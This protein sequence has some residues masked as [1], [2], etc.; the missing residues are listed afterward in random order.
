MNNGAGILQADAYT[1][2]KALYK[3]RADG[4]AQFR[5][6]ASWAHLRRDFHDIWSGTK[7]VIAKEALD[8]IGQLYDSERDIKG[9]P[10]EERHAIRQQQ[11]KPKVEDFHAW[12]EAQLTC[13]PGK[14]DLAKGPPVGPPSPCSWTIAAW[15]SAI[16]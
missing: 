12:A 7:S 14:S 3:T 15:P 9:L 16:T 2:F 4:S 13:I 6:A 8:C 1:V 11:T 10:A 5:E